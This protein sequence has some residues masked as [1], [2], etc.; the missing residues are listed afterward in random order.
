M[1]A[2]SGFELYVDATVVRGSGSCVV[3]VQDLTSDTFR[4]ED[5]PLF[6]DPTDRTMYVDGGLA[7]DL[8]LWISIT[9]STGSA[10]ANE[11][12]PLSFPMTNIVSYPHTFSLR[13][14]GGTLLLQLTDMSQVVP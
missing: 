11:D 3:E 9:D 4:Y 10:F 7:P 1:G 2:T 5:G 6:F 8:E 12:L 13:D 14:P